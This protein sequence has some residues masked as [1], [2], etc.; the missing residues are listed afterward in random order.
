MMII[1]CFIQGLGLGMLLTLAPIY[2][3]EASPGHRR[4]VLVGAFAVALGTGTNLVSWIFVGTYFSK[5]KQMQWRLTLALACVTPVFM[6]IG[7]FFILESPRWLVWKDRSEE[8]WIIL[9]K[10]HHDPADPEDTASNA[11]Y[12][13]ILKQVEHDT[14]FSL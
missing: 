3:S 8:A 7:V 1:C 13:Q 10:L 4:G 11:E 9:Q 5:D 12:V 2:I 14:K 6:C